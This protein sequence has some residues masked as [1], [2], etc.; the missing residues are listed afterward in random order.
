MGISKVKRIMVPSVATLILLALW[1]LVVR[2]GIVPSFIL[3]MPSQVLSVLIADAPLLVEHS[4]ITLAEA[5]LGLVFG[6]V[7]GFLL[8]VVMDRITLVR[9]ALQ[10]LVTISQTIP[11][12]AVA[13]LLVLWLG[14]GLAPK[15]VLVAL[16]TFFPVAVSLL[17][18]FRSVDPDLIDLLHTMQASD[19]QI[20]LRVRLPSAL[21]P[22]F[23]GLRISATYAIVG[24]VVAEWLGGF[25]GLGVYMTR[26][27]KSFSYDRMFAAI[28]VITTC[29]LA[30]MGAISA[31]K[32][33][34]MPW[35]RRE[36]SAS[37]SDGS[38]RSHVPS[39]TS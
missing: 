20:F 1:E 14:Y 23:S 39:A 17:D 24:A 11:S 15:V 9:L 7:A 26:V 4:A 16:G 12:V 2:V 30:L 34:C 32:H 31:L 8:A 27:R 3:P 10:P 6:V 35:E 18:G 25:A 29:S 38:R 33:L 13:P 21:G 28:I 19:L 22:L 36:Q 37:K 5:A